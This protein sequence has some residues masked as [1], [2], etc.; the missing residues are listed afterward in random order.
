MSKIVIRGNTQQKIDGQCRIKQAP[1]QNAFLTPDILKKDQRGSKE[2]DIAGLL[3][4]YIQ[5]KPI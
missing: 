1:G 5:A 4:M 2:Y 3:Y